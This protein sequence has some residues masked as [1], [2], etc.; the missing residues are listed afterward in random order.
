MQPETNSKHMQTKALVIT[1]DDEIAQLKNAVAQYQAKEE[2]YLQSICKSEQ[3]VASLRETIMHMESK[4]TFTEHELTAQI[5]ALTSKNQDLTFKY[6]HT[7]SDKDKA[8]SQLKDSEYEKEKLELENKELRHKL[9]LMSQEICNLKYISTKNKNKFSYGFNPI[10]NLNSIHTSFHI[11]NLIIYY[12][13]FA[14][15]FDP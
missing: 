10:S 6:I 15:I 12:N 11:S 14:V 8:I 3:H 13:Y 9:D 1:K 2:D 5:E 4:L 7:E